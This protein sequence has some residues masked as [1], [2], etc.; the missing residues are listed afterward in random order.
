M[1]K[2]RSYAEWK[3]LIAVQRASGQGVKQWCDKNGINASSMYNQIVKQR[4]LES[5]SD[6][7]QKNI[8][9]RDVEESPASVEWKELKTPAVQ[10]HIVSQKG[11][12]SIEIGNT[13]LLADDDYPVI[14]LAKLCKELLGSC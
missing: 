2:R 4:K 1:Q 14:N 12:I 10:Q 8:K 11:S 3:E 13:R 7:K 6:R 5:S 9:T